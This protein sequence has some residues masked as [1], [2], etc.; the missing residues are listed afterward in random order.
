MARST[1]SAVPWATRRSLPFFTSVSYCT[2]L[3]FGMPM[4][5]S[6]A[7]RAV[8]P[9]VTTA[10]FERADDPHDERS[11]HEQL[12]DARHPEERGAEQQP[13]EAAPEGPQLAPVLHAVA[14]VVVADDMLFRVVIL[15][16]DRQLLHVEAVLLKFADGVFGLVVGLEDRD[17]GVLV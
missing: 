10:L 3:F 4:L 17:D 8:S 5:Y 2:T 14:G 9:P 13:P 11:R 12:T 6:P 16:D 7:P 15:A 1:S